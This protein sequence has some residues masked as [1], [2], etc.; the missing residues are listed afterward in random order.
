[1]LEDA[2]RVRREKAS[3]AFNRRSLNTLFLILVPSVIVGAGIAKYGSQT[4]QIVKFVGAVIV[5]GVLALA[6]TRPAM[7]L[8]AFVALSPLDA[9]NTFL[10][11]HLRV[12]DEL[13][14]TMAVFLLPRLASAYKDVSRWLLIGLVLLVGGAAVATVFEKVN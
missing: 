6:A 14:L 8:V 1:M 9:Q 3:T 4:H 11:A 7:A 5:L 10:G 12:S 2:V 13:L